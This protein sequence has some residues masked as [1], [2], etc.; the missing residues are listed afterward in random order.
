MSFD[1]LLVMYIYQIKKY[2]LLL[3]S[4][5]EK[6]QKGLPMRH[7]TLPACRRLLFPLFPRA[8]KEIGDV[9]TQARQPWFSS[10][11]SSNVRSLS[12]LH[13]VRPAACIGS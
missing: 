8:T 3:T 11:N 5:L 6:E 7:K 12:C 1:G 4:R 10:S 2:V 13:L 9:C